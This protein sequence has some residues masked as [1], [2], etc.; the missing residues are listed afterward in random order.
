MMLNRIGEL[1]KKKWWHGVG[2]YRR[3]VKLPSGASGF[4]S[5]AGPAY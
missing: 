2:I 3:P 5:V 1:V 4:N